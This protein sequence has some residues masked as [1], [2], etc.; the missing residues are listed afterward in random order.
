MS[1]NKPK[2]DDDGFFPEHHMA[3]R[4]QE[5]MNDPMYE[6]LSAMTVVGVLQSMATEIVIE[7][8]MA[9]GQRDQDEEDGEGWKDGSEN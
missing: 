8:C 2:F 9:R 6:G 1:D 4:I 3:D 5:I 7:G